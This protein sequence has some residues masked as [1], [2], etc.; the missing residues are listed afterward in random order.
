MSKRKLTKEEWWDLNTQYQN[1][2]PCGNMIAASGEHYVLWNLL[3]RL[4]FRVP[5]DCISIMEMAEDLLSRG[6]DDE[7]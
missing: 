3:R 6:Y 4:G 2:P 7:S 1:T 5:A